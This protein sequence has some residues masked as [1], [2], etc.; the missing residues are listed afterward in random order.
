MSDTVGNVVE[1]KPR[2]CRL[3]ARQKANSL[4]RL[5]HGLQDVMEEAEMMGDG[6][7]VLLLGLVELLVAERTAGLDR[8]GGAL[9]A[10]DT[11]RPN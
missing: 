2:R 1:E 9:A 6:E 8:T 11:S 4:F 7:L 3:S 5:W 10:A